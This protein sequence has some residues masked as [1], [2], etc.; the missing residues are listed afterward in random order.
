MWKCWKVWMNGELFLET[1]KH[2]H[3]K[4]YC[5]LSNK[6]LLIMDNAP[7]HPKGLKEDLSGEYDFI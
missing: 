6:I 5:S 7:A 3:E 2:I 4:S 1:L